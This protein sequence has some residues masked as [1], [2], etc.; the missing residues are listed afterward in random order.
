MEA[1]QSQ[2]LSQ[3]GRELSTIAS[4]AWNT[5]LNGRSTACLSATIRTTMKELRAFIAD[6]IWRRASSLPSDGF[7]PRPALPGADAVPATA[8]VREET[9]D[10][11]AA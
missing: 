7:Q 3:A 5:T 8:R 4:L 10:S 1:P 6:R 2:T 9:C 11:V